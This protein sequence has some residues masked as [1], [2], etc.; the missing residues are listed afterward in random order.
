MDIKDIQ[1]AKR[2]LQDQISALL[3][4]FSEDTGLAVDV[5][6]IDNLPRMGALTGYLVSV[7]VK[8]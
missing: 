4:K 7:E 6:N 8:L 1:S 3:T 2:E 5:V